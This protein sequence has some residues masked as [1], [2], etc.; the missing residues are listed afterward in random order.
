MEQQQ[1][2]MTNDGQEKHTT[3]RNNKQWL[4]TTN[5]KQQMENRGI[6]GP[7]NNGRKIAGKWPRRCHRRLLGHRYVFFFVFSFYHY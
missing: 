5:N 7:G 3:A 6:M 1:P 4:G 2:G